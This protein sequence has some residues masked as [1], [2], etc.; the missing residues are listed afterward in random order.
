M[1]KAITKTM[2]TGKVRVTVDYHVLVVLE[3]G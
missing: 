3:N 1:L 2:G